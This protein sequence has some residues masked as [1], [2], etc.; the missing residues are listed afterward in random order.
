MFPN[1]RLLPFAW[2]CSTSGVSWKS[3]LRM[4]C[5][6]FQKKMF[7][8]I[9]Y[10]VD[11]SHHSYFYYFFI[12]FK[13]LQHF[14]WKP[15]ASTHFWERSTIWQRCLLL[16]QKCSRKANIFDCPITFSKKLWFICSQLRQTNIGQLSCIWC[17]WV[18][19]GFRRTSAVP[20]C[21]AAGLGTG[22]GSSGAHSFCP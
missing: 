6:Q 21:S 16:C 17:M 1:I 7:P 13:Y 22:T 15:A 9:I 10:W 18:C 5:F 14:V 8:R 4:L 20:L 11:G 2:N 19:E 3:I 12:N